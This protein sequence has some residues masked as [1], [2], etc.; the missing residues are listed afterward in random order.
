MGA[1]LDFWKRYFDFSGRSTRTEYFV[2]II[3]NSMIMGALSYG[4]ISSLTDYI[5]NGG[6]FSLSSVGTFGFL[7]G[8]FSLLTFIPGIS[9]WVRRL[10]DTDRSGFNIFWTIIP[11][12]GTIVMLIFLLSKGTAGY[13]RYGSN[14][15]M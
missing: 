3:I 7:G 2:P 5:I 14:S 8:I 13:N 12:I 11:L 1:Y 6:T 4:S 10:H 9:V 15:K